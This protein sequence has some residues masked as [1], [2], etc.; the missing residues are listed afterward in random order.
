MGGHTITASE[1]GKQSSYEFR[2]KTMDSRHSKVRDRH[3]SM[4]C[5]KK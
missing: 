4:Q 1:A 3:N 5:I 2:S